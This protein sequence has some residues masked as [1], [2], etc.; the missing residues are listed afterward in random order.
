VRMAEEAFIEETDIEEVKNFWGKNDF[1]ASPNNRDEAASVFGSFIQLAGLGE[2][3]IGRRGKSTRIKWK[4]NAKEIIDEILDTNKPN[5]T[6][7]G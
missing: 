6:E 7:E 4:S 3:I 2:F 5:S 1:G